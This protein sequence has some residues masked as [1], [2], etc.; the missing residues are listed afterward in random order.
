MNKT[1]LVDKIA[2]LTELE[3]V[4]VSKVVN[5]FLEV[6]TDSLSKHQTVTLI[7]FGTFKVRRRKSR[8]GV[9]PQ[10]R[11]P[12]TIPA[13]DIP[14]VSFGGNLKK[15]V[16]KKKIQKSFITATSKKVKV[17]PAKKAVSKK[18][19]PAKKTAKKRK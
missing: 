16:S 3:K 15:S 8:K 10:T 11:Q 13:A 17:A 12:M 19:K 5:A 7:G 9:N 2:S 4:K 1:E 14:V 6:V 18:A